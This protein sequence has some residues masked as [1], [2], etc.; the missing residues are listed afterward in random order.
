MITLIEADLDSWSKLDDKLYEI[1]INHEKLIF[2]NKTNR[3]KFLN[4][5]NELLLLLRSKHN[6]EE[7]H[8]SLLELALIHYHEHS[9][10]PKDPLS[11]IHY[12]FLSYISTLICSCFNQTAYFDKKVPLEFIIEEIKSNLVFQEIKNIRDKRFSHQDRKHYVHQDLL[13]WKFEKNEDGN[14]LPTK[15]SYTFE[16]INSLHRSRLD[17]WIIF[18]L[19]LIKRIDER[20]QTL[21]KEINPLLSNIRIKDCEPF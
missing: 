16:N 4:M 8:M 15:P 11:K 5:K 1:F 3:Q 7:A 12:A 6:L 2:K 19:F 10:F 9:G 18:V 21:A 14:F 17:D 20:T 13:K